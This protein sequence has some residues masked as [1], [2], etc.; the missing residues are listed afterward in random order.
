MD[1]NPIESLAFSMQAQPKLYALLLG[2]GVSRAAGVPTGWEVVLDLVG[3]LMVVQGEK[4]PDPHKWYGDK[5]GGDP[6]YSAILGEIA[7]TPAERQQILRRYFEP[8]PADEADASKRPTT[9]HRAIADLV[10]G[11]FVKVIVTTNFDRLIESALHEADV[12]PVVLKSADDIA[13]MTPLDHTKCCVL[14]LHGD[15]LDERIRNTTDELSEYPDAVNGLID[16]I[17]EEYGLVVCGWSAEWDVALSKAI[18]RA[19]ARRYTTYWTAYGTLGDEAK[20]IAQAR[21]ARVIEIESADKF[22][23]DLYGL[24]RAIEDHATPNPASVQVA[25][26]QCK[27][28]LARDEHRIRLADL[29]DSIGKEALDGL[30]ALPTLS[31]SDG[32]TI[33]NHLRRCEGVCSKLLAT[34][35]VASRWST[36]AQIDVWRSTVQML[37]QETSAGDDVGGALDAVQLKRAVERYP[38]VLLIYAL[39]IGAIEADKLEHLATILAFPTGREVESWQNGLLVRAEEDVAQ[40]LYDVMLDVARSIDRLQTIEGMEGHYC[41]MNDRLLQ[42]LREHTIAMIPLETRHEK[43]FDRMEVLISLGCSLQMDKVRRQDRRWFPVGRFV[44]R[45]GINDATIREIDESLIKKGDDSPFVRFV[46]DNAAD[47]YEFFKSL[48]HFI[49]SVRNRTHL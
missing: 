42:S 24:V 44:Y 38:V 37:I 39:G 19:R 14:K 34:A 1:I 27:Q 21:Q 36:D 22:F 29:V 17:V 15:Y 6:D 40:V 46:G 10:K 12:E 20:H 5:Y 41:P 45:G 8:D 7:P 3:K 4:A 43:I 11:G 30:A 47:G 26:A 18:R 13:G 9:A 49:A 31:T 16:R 35:V 25:V 32:T 48:F 23:E 33:T 28:Y 2:S